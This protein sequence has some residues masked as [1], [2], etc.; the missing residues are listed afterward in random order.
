MASRLRDAMSDMAETIRRVF[1]D[2][3]SHEADLAL[4]M[5]GNK[6]AILLSTRPLTPPSR[7]EPVAGSMAVLE[8]ETPLQVDFHW[9]ARL[10]EEAGWGQWATGATVCVPGLF[11]AEKCSRLDVPAL[12]RRARTLQEAPE[13]YRTRARTG[14]EPL[15]APRSALLAC[16]LPPPRTHRALDH[17]LALP[18][19]FTSEDIGKV[20]KALW[21]RYTLKLVRDTGENIRNLNVVGLYRIPARGVRQVNHQVS[22]GKLL[23]HFGPEA[24]GAPKAPFILARRKDDDS[25]VCCFVEDV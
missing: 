6:A 19:A 21:M 22:T 12:P 5:P 2:P 16:A 8:L 13:A 18:V 17:A 9:E 7:F 20:S 10:Q 11:Q 1:Q 14:L 4:P 24:E 3:P 15:P 23:V 25:V